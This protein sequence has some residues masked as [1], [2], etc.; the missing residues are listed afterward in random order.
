M[1]ML[2]TYTSIYNMYK[3]YVSPGWEQQIMLLVKVKVTLRPTTSRSVSH[4]F[5]AH[6]GLMTWYLFLLTFTSIVLLITGA[7]SDERSLK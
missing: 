2:V 7:P 6:E 5:K 1:Y 3:A 4:G